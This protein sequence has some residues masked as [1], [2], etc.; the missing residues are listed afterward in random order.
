MADEREGGGGWVWVGLLIVV[1]VFFLTRTGGH[2]YPW[3]EPGYQ[4]GPSQGQ[5]QAEA[6]SGSYA[7]AASS[8]PAGSYGAF[9]ENEERAAR[10]EPGAVASP[11]FAPSAETIRRG[12]AELQKQKDEEARSLAEEQQQ[13]IQA[14]KAELDR[15]RRELEEIQNQRRRDGARY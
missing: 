11:G 13:L 4:S 14:Q 2:N 12:Q 9:W 1:A 8:Y 5:G 15:L 3:N 7:E 10:G 6:P